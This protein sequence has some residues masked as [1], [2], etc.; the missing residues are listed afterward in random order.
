MEQLKQ[1]EWD[2]RKCPEE[3]VWDCWL[4]E[5]SREHVK[6][7]G[8]LN[9]ELEDYFTPDMQFPRT[10]FLQ[11]IK[12]GRS[13]VKSDDDFTEKSS[14]QKDIDDRDPLIT[15]L[16][17]WGRYNPIHATKNPEDE[18][19][20]WRLKINWDLSDSKL[21]D[22]FR[23]FIESARPKKHPPNELRGHKPLNARWSELKMLGAYRLLQAGFKAAKAME[24]TEKCSGMPLFSTVQSWYQAKKTVNRVL[25]RWPPPSISQPTK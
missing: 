2:F 20:I 24:Y 1:S 11:L 13:P 6:R 17:I 21:V 10:P 18:H 3:S 19:D 7:G 22:D 8:K 9:W 25:E 12:G 5:F 16:S 15:Y 4:F 14:E 23:R